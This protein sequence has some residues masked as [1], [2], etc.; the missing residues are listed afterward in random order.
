MRTPSGVLVTAA[1]RHDGAAQA[2]VHQL[3]Y[4]GSPEAA[5]I[6]GRAIATRIPGTATGIV[7]VPRARLRA[8]RHGVDPA[9]SLA[10]EVARHTGIPTVAALR[11]GWWW[12]RHAGRRGPVR[13]APSWALRC[14]AEEGWVL[15]DDVATTG[16]TLAAAA[17]V[18][19]GRPRLAFVATSP[20]RVLGRVVRAGA[21]PRREG[22]PPSWEVV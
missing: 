4:S 6:L 11:P 14:P 19:G 21:T 20:G 15:I 8:W 17:V 16:S 13:S 22:F 9:T 12:P 5:A 3:K 10:R 18:L 2:L 7:P 1:F